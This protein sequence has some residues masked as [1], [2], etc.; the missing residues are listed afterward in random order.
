MKC[1]LEFQQVVL[2]IVYY[3]LN[4]CSSIVLYC[5]QIKKEIRNR[6]ILVQQRQS[7]V[8]CLCSKTAEEKMDQ[9]VETIKLNVGFIYLF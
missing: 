2:Q 8:I 6:I 5:I 9:I 1:F 7:Y 4:Y 3:K